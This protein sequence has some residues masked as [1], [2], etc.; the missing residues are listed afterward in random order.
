MNLGT[1]SGTWKVPVNP[2]YFARKANTGGDERATMHCS[3][4]MASLVKNKQNTSAPARPR[5]PHPFATHGLNEV[6]TIDAPH[7]ERIWSARNKPEQRQSQPNGVPA[8]VDACR[9]LQIPRLH[10]ADGIYR[11]C[12]ATLVRTRADFAPPLVRVRAEFGP[13]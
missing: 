3:I 8:I 5:S 9:S 12:A 10:R 7:N 1:R 13:S 11:E 4:W 2:C 6:I